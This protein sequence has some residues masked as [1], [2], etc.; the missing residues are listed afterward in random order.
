MNELLETIVK[1]GATLGANCTIGCGNII[2]KYALIGAGAVV[3]KNVPNFALMV[4][5]PARRTGWMCKCGE[6][7]PNSLECIRCNSKYKEKDENTLTLY[8]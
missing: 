5:N 7:L 2:G 3:T 1:K 4:G 6:I 8:E